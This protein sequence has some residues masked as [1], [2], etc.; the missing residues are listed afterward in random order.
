MIFSDRQG[1]AM[2]RKWVGSGSSRDNGLVFYS[3][4]ERVHSSDAT[5]RFLIENIRFEPW[6]LNNHTRLFIAH[7]STI[8]KAYDGVLQNFSSV[9]S[10][11]TGRVVGQWIFQVRFTVKRLVCVKISLSFF[12]TW[13]LNPV[14]LWGLLQDIIGRSVFSP[15]PCWIDANITEQ[16]FRS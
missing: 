12:D 7:V 13:A 16:G 8:L 1:M 11:F 6:M 2:I 14:F 4:L 5:T 3:Y 15:D 10:L 9:W